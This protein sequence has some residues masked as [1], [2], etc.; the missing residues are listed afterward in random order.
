M[1]LLRQIYIFEIF[2][3]IIENLDLKAKQEKPI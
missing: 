1:N 2:I 3:E